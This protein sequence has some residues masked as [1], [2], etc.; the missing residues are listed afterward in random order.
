MVE[1]VTFKP[2]KLSHDL[3]PNQFLI[4]CVDSLK[5]VKSLRYEVGQGELPTAVLSVSTDETLRMAIYDVPTK[6]SR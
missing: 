4:Q 6:R 2:N 3:E 1:R 5:V